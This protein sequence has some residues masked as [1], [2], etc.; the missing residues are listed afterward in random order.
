MQQSFFYVNFHD[1]RAL[2]KDFDRMAR[3][4]AFELALKVNDAMYRIVDFEFY[5]YSH[6]FK[7]PFTHKHRQQTQRGQLYFHPSGIDITFGYNVD[8]GS[9]LI[10]GVKRISDVRSFKFFNVSQTTY[11]P[12]KVV[13][14]VFSNLHEL[15]SGKPNEIALVEIKDRNIMGPSLGYIKTARFGLSDKKEP[16]GKFKDMPL[17]YIVLFEHNGGGDDKVPDIEKLLEAEYKR[18]RIH[19]ETI[20]K[21]LGHQKIFDK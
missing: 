9:I 4:L 19:Q 6:H 1:K 5:A 3:Y 14:E 10:R 11:D 8:Y 13:T 20:T 18:N 15:N 12:R 17:R 7:D 2:L 21:I 16:K